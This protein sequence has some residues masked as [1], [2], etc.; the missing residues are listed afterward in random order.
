MREAPKTR[1]GMS[2]GQHCKCAKL[3][4]LSRAGK[5]CKRGDPAARESAQTPKSSLR[6]ASAMGSARGRASSR[7]KVA[8]GTTECMEQSIVFHLHV[9]M[10]QVRWR[11]TCVSR[12]A[13]WQYIVGKTPPRPE[14]PRFFYFRY[15][16]TPE[17][18]IFDH[19]HP[20]FVIFFC[21]T[22]P[23]SPPSPLFFYTHPARHGLM[24]GTPPRL[25]RRPNGAPAAG[26]GLPGSTSS[27]SI[28]P[29]AAAERGL[30]LSRARGW[31]IFN[32]GNVSPPPPRHLRPQGRRPPRTR[33]GSTSQRPS[34]AARVI[35]LRPQ[36][37]RKSAADV[38]STPRRGLK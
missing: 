18:P 31:R 13:L 6:W 10:W 2:E 27:A 23:F 16:Y 8:D 19:L 11:K 33:S 20:H 35:S 5:R 15:F 22:P 26:G 21:F 29:P 4:Q 36:I 37:S 38:D 34:S 9:G 25:Q 7:T 30:Y 14:G 17:C 3:Q 12:G 28:A 1:G 24:E 32:T